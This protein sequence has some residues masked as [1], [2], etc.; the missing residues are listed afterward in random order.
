MRWIVFYSII[1]SG[2]STHQPKNGTSIVYKP[3][4]Q[5]L[6]KEV[7]PY[8]QKLEPT[9]KEKVK[10]QQQKECLD[11]IEASYKHTGHTESPSLLQQI[12]DANSC[13]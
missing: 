5:E 8:G 4:K 3:V 11:R 2:C 10:L 9:L 12:I 13:S 7:A 6:L 1:F